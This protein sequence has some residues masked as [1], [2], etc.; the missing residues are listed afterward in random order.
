VQTTDDAA[1]RRAGKR[2]WVGLGV[3][4]LACLLYAMDLTVLH[5]AVPKLSSDLEP[6]SAQLLWIIDIYGFMIAASLITMGTLGD[7][8]GR[9]RL[10]MIGAAAF[11]L[12]S[13]VAA[14]SVSAEM[15]I[16]SRAAQGIAGAT[17]APS[18]LALIF[19]MVQD[20]R[21]RQVAIGIWVAAFSAGGAIGP[22]LGGVLLE[23]FWWGSVFLLAVPVMALLLIL[24]PRLLPEYRAPDAGRLDIPSALMSLSAILAVI[25]GLKE[26]ARDGVGPVPVAAFA[27]GLA[28]GAAF[29]RRQLTLADP[30]VDL[31]LFANPTYS[32]SLATNILAVFIAVGYFLFVAQYL[33]LVLGLSPLE[34]GLWSLPAA[35]GFIVGSNLAPR[36]LRRVRPAFVV[37]AG[38]TLG[39]IGLWLLTRAD[40]AGDL[41]LIV[42]SSI[43]V[44]LGL[45]PVFTAT[46]ELV[47]G[48][49]PPDRAGLASGL[50]EAG[51]ELGGALGIAILGSVG[52]A[53]YRSELTELGAAGIPAGAAAAAR[54]TLG[55]AVGVADRLPGPLGVELVEAARRAFV[56]GMRVSTAIAATGAVAVA[57]LAVA[58]LRNIR[59][60]A[61]GSAMPG[62][63]TDEPT[64]DALYQAHELVE[65]EA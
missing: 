35:A 19:V 27:V 18:T 11:G 30:V 17:L 12:V 24:G 31:R 40:G 7:R 48:S 63:E 54:D 52:T 25:F 10:L 22:V 61:A 28:M 38:F 41:P 55:A 43:I 6:T 29:L 21:Q 1:A 59:S 36:T 65:H 23:R 62:D 32:A 45:A 47:V 56:Q 51:A 58:M 33:Q 49:G 64:S 42:A 4:T 5:L 13:V 37:C 39:A 60:S 15:L 34:A 50:S 53:V 9:R 46:T 20:P 14:F 8:I 16:A 3:L 26:L 57:A 2:E 44:S